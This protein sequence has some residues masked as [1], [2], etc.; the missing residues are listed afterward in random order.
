MC[1]ARLQQARSRAL[2][3]TYEAPRGRERLP[4]YGRKLAGQADACP[5]ALPTTE[6]ASELR[7]PEQLLAEIRGRT[8]GAVMSVPLRQLPFA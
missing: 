5:V 4:S 1:R 2:T 3:W 6:R 8:V 7:H